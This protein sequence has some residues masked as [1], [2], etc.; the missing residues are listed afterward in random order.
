MNLGTKRYRRAIL[1]IAFLASSAVAPSVI[2]GTSAPQSFEFRGARLGMTIEEFEALPA[3]GTIRL[4]EYNERG[5]KL[6]VGL[7]TLC[8][9]EKDRVNAQIGVVE[10]KRAGD[11][12]F[13]PQRYRY[14]YTSISYKFGPDADGAKRLFSILIITGRDNQSEAVSGLRTKWGDG[15]LETSTVTNGLGQPLP[16]TTEAWRRANGTIELESPCGSVTTICMTYSDTGL[17]A[18]LASRRAAITGG[19][20]TRF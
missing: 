18:S 6:R 7:L 5:K 3:L 4:S 16:K 8:A 17:V 12:P 11:D 13:T 14:I 19:P 20:A 1:S 10:C 2:A 15:K 9:P